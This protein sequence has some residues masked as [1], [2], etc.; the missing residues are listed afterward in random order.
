MLIEKPD[1]AARSSLFLVLC[2]AD[3]RLSPIHINSKIV[4]E[5]PMNTETLTI[6]EEGQVHRKKRSDAGKP[7]GPHKPRQACQITSQDNGTSLIALTGTHGTGKTLRVSTADLPDLMAFTDS[8]K[9]LHVV[10]D[11][12]GK[13][14]TLC[15]D[16]TNA[17]AWKHSEKQSDL[18]TAARFLVG[19]THGG[20][21]IR[22]KDHNS[23][24]LTRNNLEVLVPAIE[25]TF[26]ID[27]EKA[28]AARQA[29]MQACS[30]HSQVVSR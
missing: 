10:M 19:E 4:T 28:V 5:K 18:V 13:H 22:F 20:R 15:I 17:Q 27:W 24:N 3:S 23:F 2:I 14:P 26:T 8:G 7:H 30:A 29:K 9:H 12:H 25:E 21:R 1:K 11:G 16:G 6:P